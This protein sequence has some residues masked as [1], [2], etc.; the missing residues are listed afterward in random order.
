MAAPQLE[1]Q[2]EKQADWEQERVR[3]RV[4]LGT[5]LQTDPNTQQV[6]AAT[7][8]LYLLNE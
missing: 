7:F 5:L 4:A 8:T 6:V 3:N 2:T 1:V